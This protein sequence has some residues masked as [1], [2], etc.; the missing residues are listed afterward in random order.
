MA[1]APGQCQTVPMAGTVA[2]DWQS[3]AEAPRAG[4]SGS[5]AASGSAEW[6]NGSPR[7]VVIAYRQSACTGRLLPA[8]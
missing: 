1:P 2:D 3:T 4:H 5:L 6:W 7:M 8:V